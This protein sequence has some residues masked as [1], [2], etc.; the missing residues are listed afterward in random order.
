MSALLPILRRFFMSF[1]ATA[2][3]VVL[4]ACS[5]GGTSTQ[6]VTVPAPSGLTY[7]SNTAIYTKGIAVTP[8]TPSSGGGAVVSYAISPALP[9][10]LAFNTSTGA[11]SGT[12]TVLTPL[13]TYTVTAT[14]TGGSTLA[15]ISITVNDAAPSGLT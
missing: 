3:L 9:M 5:S 13:A 11:I 8:N 7:S 12:P 4:V 10:G 15:T 6:P 2:G 1:L 14:N